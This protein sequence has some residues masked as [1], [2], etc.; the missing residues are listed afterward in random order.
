MKLRPRFRNYMHGAPEP[1]RCRTVFLKCAAWNIGSII[2]SGQWIYFHGAWN[3]SSPERFEPRSV[4]GHGHVL[5]Y[6]GVALV[7][8][9][10]LK[11]PR[12]QWFDATL[13]LW[14]TRWSVHRIKKLV[15]GEL[16]ADSA[17]WGR[18]SCGIACSE[19]LAF[20]DL[21]FDRG[22]KHPKRR[23]DDPALLLR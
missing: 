5:P 19:H 6:A 14:R 9:D 4:S 23:R 2:V 21:A 16:S 20:C 7:R 13:C 3:V 10:D 12:S 18:R 1:D 8:C 17:R 11:A 15:A 22:D